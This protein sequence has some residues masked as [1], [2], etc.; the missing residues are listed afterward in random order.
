M[1]FDVNMNVHVWV[2]NMVSCVVGRC[3]VSL[4]IVAMLYIL[5]V[6][7]FGSKIHSLLIMVGISA[8]NVRG[9]LQILISF[10]YLYVQ[11]KGAVRG[12]LSQ[13]SG[14]LSW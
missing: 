8:G 11:V 7:I 13:H 2:M 4:L 6:L 3:S 1:R 5:S 14:V 10:S 9:L 12:E